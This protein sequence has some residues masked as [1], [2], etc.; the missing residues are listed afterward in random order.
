MSVVILSLCKNFDRQNPSRLLGIM[1][2]V[3]IWKA[4]QTPRESEWE[5][6]AIREQS[7]MKS[8]ASDKLTASASKSWI[9]SLRSSLYTTLKW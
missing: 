1:L 6:R 7:E 9:E 2:N 3:P 4:H 5:L 8:L